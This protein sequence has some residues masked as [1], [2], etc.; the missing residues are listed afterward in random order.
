MHLLSVLLSGFIAIGVIRPLRAAEM[1]ASAVDRLRALNHVV[2]AH[3]H[4][5]AA[6]PGQP[7]AIL[8]L[9]WFHNGDPREAVWDTVDREGGTREY[10]VVYNHAVQG[11][12]AN[13]AMANVP[14]LRMLLRRLP[15][16]PSLRPPQARWL[17]LSFEDGANWKRRVYD[18]ANLP[19]ELK[20]V[21]R[22]A[23]AYVAT[24]VPTLRPS[25]NLTLSN[26]VTAL[27]LS[28]DGRLLAAGD[29]NSTVRV[30]EVKTGTEILQS[31]QHFQ[32][33]VRAVM[34]LPDAKLLVAASYDR[35]AL[36]DA[37]TGN[38]VRAWWA[39]NAYI[40]SGAVN[41]DGKTLVTGGRPV[42][43]WDLTSGT[44]IAR[45]GEKSNLVQSVVFSPDG[46]WV[47]SG[48]EDKIV[49]LWGVPGGRAGAN[50]PL[51]QGIVG[52]DFDPVGH[53]LA[54]ADSSF[55]LRSSIWRIS[56]VKQSGVLECRT[57]THTENASAIAWSPDGKLLAVGAVNGPIQLWQ[58]Q[59]AKPFATLVG[60]WSRVTGLKFLP[61]GKTLVSSSSDK[62]IKFWDL[63]RVA[64]SKN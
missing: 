39:T 49:R 54:V 48:G 20:A 19:P 55:S 38:R 15:S 6:Y 5:E 61:S 4:P 43:L 35:I 37:L 2:F 59:P 40:L 12:G 13:P 57:D 51:R 52:L 50:L 14:E 58:A 29:Q 44:E 36:I 3:E 30:W 21:F 26:D 25:R 1:D 28:R 31:D 47:A 60:Q 45:M 34:F 33:P 56:D 62:T 17:L 9:T 46:K 24:W 8:M 7:K 16:E 64:A 63:E 11:T 27:D 53:R 32:E 10:R 23:N 22:L 18:R 42:V 41:R